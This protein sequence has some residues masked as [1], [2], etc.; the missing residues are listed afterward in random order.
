MT[1]LGV[2]IS[3]L[4]DPALEE[5]AMNAKSK[6]ADALRGQRA[7]RDHAT[8]RDEVRL[9]EGTQRQALRELHRQW[10]ARRVRRRLVNAAADAVEPAV[11][12]PSRA[13]SRT[14]RSGRSWSR[15]TAKPRSPPSTRSTTTPGIPARRRG[16]RNGSD[17][18]RDLLGHRDDRGPADLPRQQPARRRD[19]EEPRVWHGQPRPGDDRRRARRHAGRGHRHRL[20]RRP[21]RQRPAGRPVDDPQ[22]DML[23]CAWSREISARKQAAPVC[24]A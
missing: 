19:A 12:L 6:L 22:T 15:S 3:V 18:V 10:P 21:S 4:P 16:A 20:R 5:T 24:A 1:T 2:V 11:P 23:P 9:G 8:L 7:L 17:P 13:T 14:C